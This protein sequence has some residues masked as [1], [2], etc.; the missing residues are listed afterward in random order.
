MTIADGEL[1]SIALCWRL[2]RTD[3][4]GVGLTSHDQAIVHEGVQY[5]PAPGMVPAAIKRSLGLQAGSG[6][7]TGALSSD[8]L[9]EHDL[10]LGRWDDPL[11]P[12]RTV[13]HEEI[14]A[15]RGRAPASAARPRRRRTR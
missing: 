5:D 4:A 9:D 2:E 13:D 14:A 12:V 6:E 1:T 11:L 7:V 3:G 15:P 10:A 8:A